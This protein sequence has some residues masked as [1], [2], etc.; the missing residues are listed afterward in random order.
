GAGVVAGAELL[1]SSDA[2][3][4]VPSGYPA[5]RQ[6]MSAGSGAENGPQ[7]VSDITPDNDWRPGARYA[8]N[9]EPLGRGV[10]PLIIRDRLVEPEPGQASRLFE[11]ETKAGIASAPVCPLEPP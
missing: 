5:Q 11:A 4:V 1:A 7:V 6:G 2:W 8:Q 10:R 9:R 3:P